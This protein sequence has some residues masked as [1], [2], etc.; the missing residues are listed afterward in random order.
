M[1]R[2]MRQSAAKAIFSYWQSLA[3]E[4]GVAPARSAIE[5]RHLKPHLPDIFILERL[6]RA[7]FAFRLAGTRLCARYGRELRDH[8]FIRLWPAADHGLMLEA[9][10]RCL[11]APEPVA[12]RGVAATLDGRSVAFDLLLLPIADSD[13][14]VTR[15]MGALLPED[16]R[17]LREGA[18]YVSQTIERAVEAE[19]ETIASAA[20]AEA[21][22][23]H[24]AF[25]RV[26]DGTAAQPAAPQP[27][28]AALPLSD[29]I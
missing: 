26:I 13:G 3:P 9:L 28:R 8:D 24:V 14:Q 17:A 25:L 18:I 19:L 12:L 6:D 4:A 2:V 27:R 22:E 7:V 20:F 11:Q 10:N 16:D 23:T 15:I 21:R 1:G 5:P 29:A